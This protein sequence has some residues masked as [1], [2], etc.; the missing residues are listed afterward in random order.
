MIVEKGDKSMSIHRALT[1]ALIVLM[2]VLSACQSSQ[3]PTNHSNEMPQTLNWQVP[4]FD[5]IDH[6][7]QHVSR[8]DLKGKVWLA[9]FVFT[10][11]NTV[12]PPMTANMANIQSR[13]KEEQLDVEMI[14]FTVDPDRD[15]PGALKAFGHNHGMTEGN[16]R[17]LTGYSR[18]DIET[19]SR[20]G[21]KS[22]ISDVPNSDQINH[23]TS[24]FLI[25]QDGMIIHRFDG[26]QPNIDVIVQAIRDLQ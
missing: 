20:E 25:D 16:W 22:Q 21:F 14:S 10:N 4:A 23:V 18:E 13:L 11:C 26:I 8:E 2:V 24:F 5:Y 3:Q 19:F 15:T 9:N 17:F 6:N 1:I 12:C 7:G